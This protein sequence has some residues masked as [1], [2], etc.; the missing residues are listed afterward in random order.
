M[1]LTR[2]WSGYGQC[3]YWDLGSGVAIPITFPS[4]LVSSDKAT[5]GLR[6][7]VLRWLA[8]VT[9]AVAM[10]ALATA[11]WV[12]VVAS[13]K[14]VA[15]V[16]IAAAAAPLDYLAVMALVPSKVVSDEVAIAMVSAREPLLLVSCV[17]VLAGLAVLV[18]MTLYR[19]FRRSPRGI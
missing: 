18:M 10:V 19:L 2:T 3:E 15:V 7:E 17:T 13:T 14:L 4:F 1:D 11:I 5:T 6:L 12:R 9:E 16:V 8:G